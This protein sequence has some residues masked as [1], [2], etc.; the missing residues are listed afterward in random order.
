M[1]VSGKEI[2]FAYIDHWARRLDLIEIWDA[3][4]RRLQEKS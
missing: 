4:K 3:V 1:K 2:D